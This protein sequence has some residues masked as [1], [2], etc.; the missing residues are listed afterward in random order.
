[1]STEDAAV[2]RRAD[3]LHARYML[4]FAGRPRI[5]RRVEELDAIIADG[6]ALLEEAGRLLGH[7]A[8]AV[9]LI[10]ANMEVYASERDAI[11]EAKK[12]GP[13]A[14]RAAMLGSRANALF[15]LYRRHFAGQ[16]R[17]TRDRFLLDDLLDALA[18]VKAELIA[19]S[20]TD[21]S[22]TATEQIGP[23]ER[24]VELYVAERENIIAAQDGASPDDRSGILGAVANQ[25]FE[26]YR[27]H[28]AGQPRLSRRVA[29][30]ERLVR[31]LEWCQQG[32][33]SLAADGVQ[34][35]MNEKNAGIVAERLG[36]YRAEIEAIR[37]ARQAAS[38]FE[39]IDALGEAANKVMAE[40]G[41][42]FAG[43]NRATRELDLLAALQDRLVET[44]RQM[45]ALTKVHDN[46][47]NDRNIIIV[48]DTIALYAR[49]ADAIRQAQSN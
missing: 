34:A 6:R 35:E 18:E 12:L 27:I 48:H 11:H 25:Q 33:R 13:S 32:M 39:L 20:G 40:Y 22:G 17:A 8:E 14:R 26:T 49:E 15:G 10:R 23:I 16:S 37:A 2:R 29:L 38:V 21:P 41:E 36:V 9:G 19:L 46:P 5:T 44:E 47:A 7:D 4:A 30:A 28:F 24:N 42:H 3:E 43:Q 45:W 1:M 31:A